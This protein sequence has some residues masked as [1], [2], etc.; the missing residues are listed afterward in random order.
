MEKWLHEDVWCAN[1]LSV[2]AF[3]PLA[4]LIIFFS[5][6]CTSGTVSDSRIAMDTL[7]TVSIPEKDS[8][9]IDDI[10]ALVYEIDGELSRYND[11]SWIYKINEN[12]GISPVSV[13]EEVFNLISA[14]I[15]MAFDTDGLFNPA[16]GPLSALWGIGSEDARVP[17]KDEIEAVLPLLDY[18]LVELSEEDL[19]VYLPLPG[20]ALDLGGVGKGYAAD[21]IQELL[22]SFGVSGAIVNLGGN[23]LAY[24]SGDGGRPWRIGIR[25]PEGESSDSVMSIECEDMTVITSG[26]YQR[27]LEKDGVRYH[28]ILDSKTGYPAVSD[29]VSATVISSSG[30]LGDMLST[31]LL[32][33][34][35]E[36]AMD[37]AAEYGVRCILI[38]SDGSVLDSSEGQI[39][40]LQK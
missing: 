11:E 39:A 40:V 6:S 18:T 9:Y 3:L 17:E 8:E 27:Y 26:V 5:V 15:D 14:S 37:I 38:L 33:A 10:F 24:G 16:I 30:T 25:N 34:G 23:V 1:H 19:S 2:K 21:R 32:A 28:Q 7:I 4:I 31:T 20:M 13:P 35:S 29:I 12:A 22:D 36:K